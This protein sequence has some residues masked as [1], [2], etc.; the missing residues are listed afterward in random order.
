MPHVEL[1][2]WNFNVPVEERTDHCPEFLRDTTEKD[3]RYIGMRDAEFE[4][5]SWEQVVKLISMLISYSLRVLAEYQCTPIP[6][7]MYT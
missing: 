7:D 2:W 3:M 6:Q 4:R 1:P 5:F